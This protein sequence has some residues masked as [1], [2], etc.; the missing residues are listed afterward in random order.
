MSADAAPTESPPRPVAARLPFWRTA[1]F[2]V[3]HVLVMYTGCVAVPLVFGA[4]LGLDQSTIATLVNA[5]LLVAGIITVVQALG[6]GSLLGAR[7]PVVAGASFTAVTPMILIGQEY[8]LS[9]V[10]GAMIAAGVFGVLVAV[11]FTRLLRFF[12]PMVRGAA[13]TMIGLSLIGKA[14]SMT[15]EGEPASGARLALAA[16][17]VVTIVALMRYG[18][19]VVAQSAVLIAL[20]LGTLVAAACSMAD[21]GAVGSAAWLGL[22]NPFLFGAPTFPIAGIVAMCLVMLVIFIESTAY[23]MSTAETIGMPAEPRRFAGGLG[24]DG[25]SAVLAGFLTSFPD[26]IFAQNVSLV[27]MTG[28]ASRAAVAVAG[29][30]LVTLGLVPKMGEVVASL[31]GPVIGSVSL[32]MFATVAGVGIATL[33]KVDFARNDNLL[34]V[35]LAMGAGMIPIVAPELYDSMPSSVKIIAGGAITSTVLVAFTLNLLFNHLTPARKAEPA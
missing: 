24:A 34:V 20:V 3:Q 16:G 6:I 30:L 18:R 8:G 10:Y 29:A 5:D 32:V 11:P 1:L 27:R 31:P 22:P 19:G 33:A 14:V 28:V 13:V 2:G 15:F 25:V 35:S 26:T 12:P 4:A 17:V 21:F 7:M 23:L 9:A